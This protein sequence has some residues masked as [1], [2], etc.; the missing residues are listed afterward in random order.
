MGIKPE[1]AL[2][3]FGIFKRLH[4]SSYPG[5]GIGLAICERI[6]KSYGGQIWVESIP[7]RGS[8]FYFTL[9]DRSEG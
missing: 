8:T 4:G 3:V 5:T 2:Q 9:P 7:E 6:V 1:Y